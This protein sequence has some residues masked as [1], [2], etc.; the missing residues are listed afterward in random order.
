[1]NLMASDGFELVM[2]IYC[3][4]GHVWKTDSFFLGQ[5]LLAV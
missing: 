5:L 2:V 1:M 3:L 4:Q